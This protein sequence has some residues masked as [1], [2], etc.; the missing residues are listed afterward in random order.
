MVAMLF[1]YA[2]AF[3]AVAMLVLAGLAWFPSRGTGRL[4]RLD[5]GLAWSAALVQL[6]LVPVDVTGALGSGSPARLD[7]WWKSCYWYAW[8]I[9]VLVL[10]VH[11][12]LTRRGEFDPV[13]RLRGALRYNV[14]YYGVLLGVASLGVLAL[15]FSGR[16]EPRNVIG[17]SIAFSNAY[18]LAGAIFLMGYGLVAVPRSL[19]RS[20][21]LDAQLDRAARAVAAHAARARD[22]HVKLSEVALRAR[23]ASVL[24]GPRDPLRPAMDAVLAELEPVGGAAFAP[25][26]DARPPG[27]DDLDVF[28][29]AD[30]AQL[31]RTLVA[32][33]RDAERE[34]ALYGEA[35]AAALGLEAVAAKTAEGPPGP[36]A[37]F[38]ERRSWLL[39]CVA[40]F[41]I[42]RALAV[43]A[44][45]ASVCVVLAETTMSPKLPDLSVF[46]RIIRAARGSPL[47]GEAVVLLCLAYPCACAYYAVYRMGNLSFYRMVPGHTDAYSLCYSALLVCRFAT[48]LAFNFMAAIA[49]PAGRNASAPN[50]NNLGAAAAATAAVAAT[51]AMTT[52]AAR[53]GRSLLFK[54]F[55]SSPAAPLGTSPGAGLG[56][57]AMGGLG[58]S[59]GAESAGGFGWSSSFSPSPSLSSS[60]LLATAASAA[61]SVAAS[62]SLSAA[63]A[64]ASSVAHDVT[65]TRF[66]AIFGKLMESQ[67]LIG[68][69]FTTFAPVA[70]APYCLLVALGLFDPIAKLL[71]SR[72]GRLVFR[73]DGDGEAS[74]AAVGRRLL[75]AEAE[76]ASR[77]AELGSGLQLGAAPGDGRGA[78]RWRAPPQA[79][80]LA[81]LLGGNAPVSPTASFTAAGGPHSAGGA[82][83]SFHGPAPNLASRL[84]TALATALGR[85]RD[86]GGSFGS[87]HGTGQGVSSAAAA[88]GAAA[89]GG[90][91]RG[92]WWPAEGG[93][94]GLGTGGRGGGSSGTLATD[95]LLGPSTGSG[96]ESIFGGSGSAGRDVFASL[97]SDAALSGWR[98]K[99]VGGTGG[100]G[101]NV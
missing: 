98:A 21:D 68:W 3:P 93:G 34:R 5:V 89:G 4:V 77:G 55:A 61:A 49:A 85:T 69:R 13:T 8:L 92:L 72:G 43:A 70:L 95:A 46:S 57:A 6:A 36:S 52:T 35:V 97:D 40:P 24:F 99:Y 22:A 23:A 44:V 20:A 100:N 29:L 96:T 81:R 26:P 53:G 65:G 67:P 15:L 73:D 37:S 88:M 86:S 11:M 71:G 31:R 42:R 83:G 32:A 12:E 48:P 54:L 27:D 78:S 2:L 58:A 64:S 14:T 91:G 101:H 9:Q 33:A 16:L 59:P 90:T 30:L 28:D 56:A 62:P 76:A 75:R 19:W 38:A 7:L 74:A 10:P 41:W 80:A 79:A 66:Y 94:G 60:S 39:E 47:L 50:K 63:S 25:S 45:V 18:G 51:Q 1:L 17:F 82:A 84:S 87:H